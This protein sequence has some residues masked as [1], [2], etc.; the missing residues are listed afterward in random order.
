MIEGGGKTLAVDERPAQSHYA[1]LRVIGIWNHC[2]KGAWSAAVHHGRSDDD[3]ARRRPTPLCKRSPKIVGIVKVRFIS[4][5]TVSA[6]L[7][8][9]ADATR[10]RPTPLI[11]NIERI[12]RD[13]SGVHFKNTHRRLM[14]E[15]K[16]RHFLHPLAGRAASENKWLA[17]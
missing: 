13:L 2:Q 11:F 5:S 9:P 10:R 12:A 4:T 6:W 7:A 17:G 16:S 14:A 15:K 8:T 1:R 3:A